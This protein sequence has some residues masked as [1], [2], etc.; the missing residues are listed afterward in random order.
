MIVVAEYRKTGY[1]IAD[2]FKTNP[3]AGRRIFHVDTKKLGTDDIKVIVQAAKDTAPHGY[4][5]H[6]CE[7]S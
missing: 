6:K 1:S 3:M 4:E 7:P 2:A 5:L